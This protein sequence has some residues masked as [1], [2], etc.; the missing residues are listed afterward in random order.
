MA[1]KK[2]EEEALAQEKKPDNSQAIQHDAKDIE[3]NVTFEPHIEKRSADEIGDRVASNRMADDTDNLES[4][5]PR[6]SE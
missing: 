4:H 2:K 6:F 5:T 3:I 1:Q